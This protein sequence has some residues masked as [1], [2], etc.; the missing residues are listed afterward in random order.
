MDIDFF[1]QYNDTYGHLQGDVALK[2]VANIL[3]EKTRHSYDYAFRIGGEEFAALR[4]C[5]NYEGTIQFAEEIKH[6]VEKLN[7][8]HKTSSVANHL[9]VSIGIGCFKIPN[10]HSRDEMFK[11]VDDLLYQ[12]KN[13]GRNQVCSLNIDY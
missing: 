8:S 6:A 5:D 13:S 2:H 10:N 7:I 11:E 3:I 4:L 1:K 9:S 12:A